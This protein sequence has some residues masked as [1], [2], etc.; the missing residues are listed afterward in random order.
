MKRPAFPSSPRRAPVP[1]EPNGSTR[2]TS[3]IISSIRPALTACAV[4]MLLGLA[5][6]LALGYGR[7]ARRTAAGLTHEA[8]AL[9]RP[10]FRLGLPLMTGL[11]RLDALLLRIPLSGQAEHREAF[12][13]ESRAWSTRVADARAVTG[14]DPARQEALRQV[15]VALD[16]YL[17]T[18]SDWLA[19]DRPSLRRDTAAQL[20][21][22]IDAASAPLRKATE[23]L[24]A[25]E[26]AS[27]SAWRT[28]TVAALAAAPT[29]LAI[30]S[31]AVLTLAAAA[32][33]L[34][35][36]GSVRPLRA[37]LREQHAAGQQ[38]DH[39]TQLG[40]VAAGVV[41]EVRNPL[42]AIK[43]RA[44]QLRRSL[45]EATADLT[46]IE[47]EIRRL[48]RI[49]DDFLQFARPAE[50]RRETV[51]A[52]GLLRGIQDLVSRPLA[53]R[54]VT[55]HLEAP[56]DLTLDADPAQLRQV[57]LNLVRN[58]ADSLT[59]GGS[60][61]L[62]ARAGMDSRS[63]PASPVVM[64]EVA[65]SGAGIPPEVQARLFEP[66]V[67]TKPCGTG[68]GLSIA[69]RLVEAHGGHLQYQTRPGHGTVFTMVLPG[70]SRRPA[71][72]DPPPPATGFP[73]G[74]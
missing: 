53:E 39:L 70:P 27:A 46:V 26:E 69:A 34:T 16:A 65:D 22:G 9:D 57:L 12:L 14:V 10:E 31:L 2:G 63:R 50:P 4:L 28:R 43:T 19:R 71:P 67:S 1:G 17:A 35:W 24:M 23:T 32:V 38:R 45:P 30:L 64:L 15:S 61:I 41:H 52:A 8:H 40:V 44:H 25:A 73:P 48:D 68:L 18:A 72:A 36:H 62:R 58:A 55:V 7:S 56:N 54:R 47:D 33:A 60:I 51:D 11:E 6:V 5:V 59:D 29:R 20:A 13:A 66:F 21:A 74:S 42:T 49:L 3:G 37:A